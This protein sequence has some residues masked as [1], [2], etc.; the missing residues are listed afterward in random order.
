MLPRSADTDT[1][2]EAFRRYGGLDHDN[3]VVGSFGGSPE[4]ATELADFGHHRDR[5]GHGQLDTRLR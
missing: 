1:P 3:Y 2:W 5:E 4:M